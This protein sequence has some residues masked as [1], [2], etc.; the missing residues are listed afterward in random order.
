MQIHL[1]KKSLE[2]LASRS[3]S[4]I[5]ALRDREHVP[6]VK[7]C[8]NRCERCE[9]GELIGIADGTPFGAPSVDAFLESL[10]ALADDDEL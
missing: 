9:R 6:A 5:E 4:L 10:D 3:A 2:R 7:D 8:L 1:C